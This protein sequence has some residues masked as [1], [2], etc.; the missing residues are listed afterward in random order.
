[1]EQRALQNLEFKNTEKTRTIEGTEFL[2]KS[3]KKNVEHV[4]VIRLPFREECSYIFFKNLNSK[5]YAREIVPDL[6]EEFSIDSK[7]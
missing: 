2:K 7:N 4:N 5:N 6:V 3:F 1:M